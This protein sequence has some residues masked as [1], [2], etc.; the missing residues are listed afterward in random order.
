VVCACLVEVQNGGF[1]EC[2]LTLFMVFGNG[3]LG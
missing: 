2:C 1:D 3:E